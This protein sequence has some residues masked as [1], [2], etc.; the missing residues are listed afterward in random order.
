MR[1][2]NIKS[3]LTAFKNGAENIL[4]RDCYTVLLTPHPKNPPYVL[5]QPQMFP[6]QC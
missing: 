2:V 6:N 5:T 1:A 4:G 3:L